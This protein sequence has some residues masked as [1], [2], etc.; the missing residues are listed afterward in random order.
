LHNNFELATAVLVALLLQDLLPVQNHC[1]A[2]ILGATAR[3][4]DWPAELI[5]WKFMQLDTIWIQKTQLSL[6]K[7]F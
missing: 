6:G 2:I 4:V 3:E 7:F 5:E 1:A